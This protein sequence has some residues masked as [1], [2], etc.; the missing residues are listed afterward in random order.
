MRTRSGGWGGLMSCLP[1]CSKFLSSSQKGLGGTWGTPDFRRQPATR[2]S[3]VG[4]MT[5][6]LT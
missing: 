5:K 1:P 6:N 3:M 2:K 4:E